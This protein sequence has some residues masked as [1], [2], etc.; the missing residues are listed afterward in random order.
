MRKKKEKATPTKEWTPLEISQIAEDLIIWMK[1]NQEN[2]FVDDFLYA[3]K[4]LHPQ[5]VKFLEQESEEFRKAME[6]ANAIELAKLKKFGTADRL[7]SSLVKLVL[8]NKYNWI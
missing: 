1:E 6:Q 5:D 3:I 7:N 2:I 8:V 4:F